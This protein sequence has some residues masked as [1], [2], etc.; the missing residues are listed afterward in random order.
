MTVDP[1]TIKASSGDMLEANDMLS[2]GSISGVVNDF[3]LEMPVRRLAYYSI[4]SYRDILD[5]IGN[6]ATVTFKA[7]KKEEI[8]LDYL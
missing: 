2:F 6:G 1:P 4:L 7:L 8:E 3:I 5:C